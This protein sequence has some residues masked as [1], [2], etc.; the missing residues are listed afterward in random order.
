MCDEFAEV[1]REKPPPKDSANREGIIR[2]P[3]ASNNAYP[4]YFRDRPSSLKMTLHLWTRRRT[5]CVGPNPVTTSLILVANEGALPRLGIKL[6][7]FLLQLANS[8]WHPKRAQVC[9]VR[10]HTIANLKRVR[11][12]HA[13]MAV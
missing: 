10:L 1:C 7:Q 11:P 9:K 13:L 3:A 12:S 2:L 5:P 4:S 6:P 8:A